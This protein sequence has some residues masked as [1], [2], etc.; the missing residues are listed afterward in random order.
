MLDTLKLVLASNFRFLMAKL[1]HRLVHQVV[2]LRLIYNYSTHVTMITQHTGR[3]PLKMKIPASTDF[4]LSYAT[5][6]AL[7]SPAALT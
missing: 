1:S 2:S 6:S 4:L 5:P 7:H 3:R